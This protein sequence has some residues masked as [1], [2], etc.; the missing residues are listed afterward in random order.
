MNAGKLLRSFAPSDPA[1]QNN[2]RSSPVSPR[3]SPVTIAVLK[4]ATHS[5]TNP[6]R[7]CTP[8]K[9]AGQ[10]PTGGRVRG[11]GVEN[12]ASTWA[13]NSGSF[14]P[15]GRVGLAAAAYSHSAGVGSRFPFHAAQ[16]LAANH[17]TCVTGALERAPAPKSRSAAQD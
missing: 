7:S 14:P 15:S 13:L 5:Q 8:W 11:A 4:S 1:P 9:L 17:E 3:A 12:Q 2:W 16:A 10:V 6:C